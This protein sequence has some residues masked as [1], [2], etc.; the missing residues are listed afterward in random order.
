MRLREKGAR[1]K[2][3]EHFDPKGEHFSPY[4][5]SALKQ[6]LPEVVKQNAWWRCRLRKRKPAESLPV[7]AEP[8]LA[9]EEGSF[10][11]FCR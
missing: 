5:E 8:L 9:A 11:H 3:T 7:K 10:S 4:R 1:K 6:K 2:R